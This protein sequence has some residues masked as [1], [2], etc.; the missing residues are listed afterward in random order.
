MKDLEKEKIKERIDFA[1]EYLKDKIKKENLKVSDD[2]LFAQANELGR[3]LFVRSEIG[4]S[5]KTRE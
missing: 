4:Y 2:V 5:S 1:F 3:C